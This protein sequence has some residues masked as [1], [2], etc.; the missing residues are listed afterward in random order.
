[1]ELIS[2]KFIEHKMKCESLRPEVLKLHCFSYRE[3]LIFLH[4]KT[5]SRNINIANFLSINLQFE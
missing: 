5:H 2:H 4:I 3:V 1:M